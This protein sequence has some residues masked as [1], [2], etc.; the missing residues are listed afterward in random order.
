M[1]DD[2]RNFLTTTNFGS[3]KIDLFSTNIQRGRDHG[4]CSYKQARTQYGL[5]DLTF[6]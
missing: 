3:V 5:T 6:N 1:V 2:L 4:L